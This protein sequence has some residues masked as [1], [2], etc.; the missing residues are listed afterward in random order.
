MSLLLLLSVSQATANV[1][2]YEPFADPAEAPPTGWTAANGTSGEVAGSLS[3]PGLAPSSGNHFGISGPANYS[4]P[5]FTAMTSGETYFYSLLFRMDDLSSLSTT[6]FGSN[7]ILLS[8]TTTVSNGVASFGVV[9][10]ADNASAYN[11]VFD[12]DFRGPSSG[13]SVKD[14]NLIEYSPGQTILL[15]GS[16]TNGTGEANF[17]V[18]PDSSSFGSISA[19]TPY[20]SDTGN[21]SRLIQMMLINS[22]TSASTR[23]GFSID[24]IRV[25]TSWADVTPA[26]IPEPGE[27]ALIISGVLLSVAWMRRRSRNQ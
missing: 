12:G 27:T 2:Y 16:Y 19:P 18:N 3:Y 24:E 23:P 5:T 25:G 4:S 13:S 11:L 26:N 14:P 8:P 22:G 21:N 9:K 15:I 6:G 10:D 7:L 17:W 1:V 20:I